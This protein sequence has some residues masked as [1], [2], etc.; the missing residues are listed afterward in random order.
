MDVIEGNID[1]AMFD[2]VWALVGATAFGLDDI[3]PTPYSG[4]AP[5]VE[6]QARMIGSIL[7]NRVPFKPTGSWFFVACFMA[8]M[9]LVML[10]VANKRGRVALV[11]LPVLA[12]L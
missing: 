9:T 1:Q 2:N 8:L 11:G 12:L 6:L 4:S 10:F 3:V 7:D 5:G